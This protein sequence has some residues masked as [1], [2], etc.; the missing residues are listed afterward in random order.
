M[1]K[2]KHGWADKAA[3]YKAWRY[4]WNVSGVH[5]VDQVEWRGDE[6][7]AVI[8]LT[9][10]GHIDENDIKDA[11]R[12]RIWHQYS[13]RKLRTIATALGVPF[14]VVL[15]D[16]N[17]K[18]LSV[19]QLENEDAEWVDMSRD[20]YRAWLSALQPLSSTKRTEKT[21]NMINQ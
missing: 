9:T 3:P 7:V 13:G 20:A 1:R 2:R 16:Y 10:H 12:H 19:C 17:C 11:V 5:D 18:R 4:Q 15:M 14:F 6:P 8:E 21:K